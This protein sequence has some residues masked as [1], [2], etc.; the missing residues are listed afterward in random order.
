M[1]TWIYYIWLVVFLKDD[2]ACSWRG[3]LA[4]TGPSPPDQGEDCLASFYKWFD[5]GPRPS[6]A[7]DPDST[8]PSLSVALTGTSR[9]TL[10]SS[11]QH[12]GVF[13]LAMQF[14]SSYEQGVCSALPMVWQA[15][16]GCYGTA[17]LGIHGV[18]ECTQIPQTAQVPEGD[19]TKTSGS[20]RWESQRK[21]QVQR[22]GARAPHVDTYSSTLEAGYRRQRAASVVQ[23]GPQ[24]PRA[25]GGDQSIFRDAEYA[26]SCGRSNCQSREGQ[27]QD[28]YQEP[29]LPNYTIG[30]SQETT[31]R[32]STRTSRTGSSLGRLPDLHRDLLEKGAQ[33]YQELM[34]GFDEK[35]A[36]AMTKLAAAR[37][38]I[39]ALAEKEPVKIEGAE[40]DESD[41][42][43]MTDT[44]SG[45][46]AT[47]SSED[48]QVTQAQK[49]LRITMD[50][51]LKKMPILDE[52]TPRRRQRD[53]KPP[54]QSGQAANAGE[55]PPA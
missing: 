31:A 6:Q 46:T 36:E 40:S 49:K 28:P 25:L 26:G 11:R 3:L 41:L 29:A 27:W 39:R 13:G 14:L 38:A 35:E 42:E 24:S 30:C 34:T 18:V 48:N 51:L 16:A 15:L 44:P 23:R 4:Q 21:D 37:Q 5:S 47:A 55:A 32:D 33:K 53:E 50:N 45:P 20:G 52:G 7:G 17:A 1:R 22:W 2:G 43:L 12:H 54:E 19:P 8:T 10:G 9:A